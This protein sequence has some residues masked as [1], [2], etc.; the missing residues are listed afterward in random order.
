MPEQIISLYVVSYWAFLALLPLTALAIFSR[1]ARR[2]LV[3]LLAGWFA[4]YAAS[5]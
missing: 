4:L 5:K 3:W 2:L 1:R